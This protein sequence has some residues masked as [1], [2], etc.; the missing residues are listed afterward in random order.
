MASQ[1]PTEQIAEIV[2]RLETSDD[3]D[4]LGAA[5][6]ELA[7]SDHP[8]ALRRLGELL[9]KPDFLAKLDDLD[10]PTEKTLRLRGVM[11][12]LAERPSPEVAALCLRLAHEPRFLEDDDRKVFL[13][14][15]LA[16]VRPMS[17]ETA[18]WLRKTNAE[19]WFAFN[20]PLL[21]ENASPPA[22]ELFESMMVDRDVPA[23]RRIDCLHEALVVRRT[24]LP[25]LQTAQRILARELEP[26]ISVG[27]I[28]SLFDFQGR[29]WFGLHHPQPPAWR[30]ASSDV[31]RLALE[32]AQRVHGRAGISQSLRAAIESTASTLRALLAARA[33]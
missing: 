16:A 14:E 32:I 18:E 28:E 12:A 21:A 4:E 33:S 17:A 25:I 1:D 29:R 7:R 26:E 19:G 15:A 23:E 2:R 13:L 6:L 5:A 8:E 24:R 10:A 20:A 22:L 3:R 27:L 9:R 11:A 30:S 31:L